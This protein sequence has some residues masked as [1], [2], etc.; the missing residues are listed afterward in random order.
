MQKTK[1]PLFPKGL[2]RKIKFNNYSFTNDF[3]SY[4]PPE[5]ISRT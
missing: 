3:L 5:V 4:F 2:M 1:N